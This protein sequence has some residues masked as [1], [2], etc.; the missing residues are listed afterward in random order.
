MKVALVASPRN[1]F[2]APAV[3]AVADWVNDGMDQ[4]CMTEQPFRAAMV[5]TLRFGV[6]ILERTAGVCTVM[7]GIKAS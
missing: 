6:L 1:R 2:R 5:V 7:D 4:H 3:P